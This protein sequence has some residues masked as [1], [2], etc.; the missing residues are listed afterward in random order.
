M[1]NSSRARRADCSSF[2][3]AS[4]TITRWARGTGTSRRSACSGGRASRR[5]RWPGARPGSRRG[6]PARAPAMSAAIVSSTACQVTASASSASGG[7][8][9]EHAVGLVPGGVLV[10]GA[11]LDGGEAGP[12]LGGEGDMHAGG[13]GGEG[14]GAAVGQPGGDLGVVGA[15]VGGVEGLH[16]GLQRAGVGGQRRRRHPRRR[17]AVSSATLGAAARQSGLALAPS[18][19]SLRSPSG[20][21]VV[22]VG[23]VGGAA[24]ARGG[25]VGVDRRVAAAG[26]GGEEEQ[27][28]ESVCMGEGILKSH[29]QKQATQGSHVGGL[30][31]GKTRC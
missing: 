6:R 31:R 16:V 30:D 5:A 29:S 8:G 25:V 27:G 26:E 15:L 18:S 12:E 4:S 28:E 17:P 23:V 10:L 7:R 9:L 22:G 2:L 19:R 13:R 24:R 11:L 21:P 1:A 3:P 14:R 20:S